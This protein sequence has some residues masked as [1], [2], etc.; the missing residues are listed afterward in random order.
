MPRNARI[1]IPGAL[2]HV[3]QRGNF[4]SDVFFDDT[5]R[6]F[7][8]ETL[9]E[10][11][12]LARVGIASY[13]LMTNH[14]HLLLV[15][16]DPLGLARML[17]PVHMRY[18][19]RLNFRFS[20][21]GLNWQGRFFSSPLDES[22]AWQAYR[23]V[24]ENP[25]RAKMVKHFQ[26]YAWSSAK[27]HLVHERSAFLTASD[28]WLD[29]AHQALNESTARCLT[30]EQ[31]EALRRNTKMNLPTGSPEYLDELEKKLGCHLRFRSPGRPRKG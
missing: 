11:A 27:A 20:R 7:F 30:P 4:R 6:I 28:D 25:E 8:L 1:V 26:E 22:H 3:T 9:V 13:C 2:H 19:Q 14:T 23:Y 5:D 10:Y 21:L 12:N 31:A 15:P 29:K 24:A 16:S 18:S 17:K